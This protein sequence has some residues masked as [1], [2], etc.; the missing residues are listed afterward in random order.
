MHCVDEES[1]VLVVLVGQN[2]F[3]TVEHLRNRESLVEEV[4][5]LHM[6]AVEERDENVL[7]L[8]I[9]MIETV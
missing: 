8:P 7:V 1:T 9:E 6:L 3:D 5:P 2:D 4:V